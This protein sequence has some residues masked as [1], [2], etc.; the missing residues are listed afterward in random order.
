MNVVL[1]ANNTFNNRNGQPRG[2][3]RQNQYGGH[4]GGPILRNRHF[5]FFDYEGLNNIEG[6]E[7][8]LTNVNSAPNL[9]TRSIR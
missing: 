2:A 1:N 3:M 4:L 5:F 7:Q 9:S 6:T 8:R